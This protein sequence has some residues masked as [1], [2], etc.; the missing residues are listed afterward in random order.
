MERSSTV[1]QQEDEAAKAKTLE[2][3]SAAAA[4]IVE[5]PVTVQE[6]LPT[7][8]SIPQVKRELETYVDNVLKSR[9][10]ILT[11]DGNHD[12]VKARVIM[13]QL[14]KNL[15]NTNCR[16]MCFY[17]TKNAKVLEVERESAN[18]ASAKEPTLD[19]DHFDKFMEVCDSIMKQDVD[20]CWIIAG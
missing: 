19:E 12:E 15:Q 5:Q 18:P 8:R 10:V 20:M 11:Q 3:E 16:F 7:Q 4:A 9:T 13:T 17:D 14:Y 6:Q 1:S 2:N